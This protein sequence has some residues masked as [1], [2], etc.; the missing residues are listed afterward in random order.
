MVALFTFIFFYF[1]SLGLFCV[2]NRQ[3]NSRRVQILTKGE[4]EKKG[5]YDDYTTAPDS[6]VYFL[7]DVETTGSRRNYDKIIA[8]SFL[9]YDCH[10]NMLGSF[11]RKVNPG[12]VKISAYLTKHIHSKYI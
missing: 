5:K 1:S 8:M 12:K 3:C 4:G 2:I 7:F 9:S 11:S 6:A 10:G